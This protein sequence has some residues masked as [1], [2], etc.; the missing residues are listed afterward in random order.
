M[1]LI[2]VFA[3]FFVHAP[4]TVDT[5][6]Y[7]MYLLSSPPTL[8]TAVFVRLTHPRPPTKPQR[9]GAYKFD[10]VTEYMIKHGRKNGKLDM[11][12]DFYAKYTLPK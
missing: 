8:R 7:D 11:A 3:A 6:V 5:V 10:P 12:W 2:V 1:P 9:H 4:G